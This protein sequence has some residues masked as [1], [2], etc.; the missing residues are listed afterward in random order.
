MVASSLL[1]AMELAKIGLRARDAR[2]APP[3]LRSQLSKAH[4]E[5]RAR[6]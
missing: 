3:A 4:Q 6:S 5:A 2:R 1:F